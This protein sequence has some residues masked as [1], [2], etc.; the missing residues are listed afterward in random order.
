MRLRNIILVLALLALLAVFTGGSLYYFSLRQAAFTQAE[1]HAETRIEL[2]QK[3]LALYLTEHV[4][5]VKAL[6]GMEELRHAL[7]NN[8]PA[9]IARVNP[10]LDNFAGALDL[11]ACYLMDREGVTIAASNRH[12]QDSF[13]GKNFSFRPYFK[14]AAEGRTATYLALGTT[15]GKRGIYYSHP[16]L[17]RKSS[18]VLGAAIIKASV[19]LVESLVFTSNYQGTL[20][21][22]DPNGVIFIANKPEMRFMLLWQ[23]AGKDIESIKESRQFGAGP[24]PWSGLARKENRYV[25]NRQNE[26]FLFSSRKMQHYPGWQIVHLRSHRAIEKK[27]ADPFLTVIGPVILVVSLLTGLSIFILYS[28][29]LQEI[30]RRKTAEKELR[31]NEEKYRHIYHKTPVMLHS[32]DTKGKIIRVSDHWLEKMGYQRGEVIGRNLTRFYTES[33]KR[34][35]EEV[36][37]P[38][39]FRTGFCRNIP[40]TYVKKDG[41]TIDILLSCY[42]VRNQQGTVERSLAVSVDVTEKNQ[43]QNA[44]EQAKEKLSRYS[45]NLEQQVEKRTAELESTRDTLRKLSKNIMD[46]QERERGVLARELH[47]HLGQVLTALRI[48]AVGIAG[49]LDPGDKKGAVRADRICSLIDAT[50]DDVRD[51]AFRLR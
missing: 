48:D 14:K 41:K 21:V 50:I 39:F 31:L 16:V 9:S 45:G 7:K 13:V 40:Y 37:F 18:E 43:V 25:E 26:E 2:L 17:D 28:K 8:T 51:M 38:V 6:A 35:A 3:Q 24:W 32:I 42:G 19:E 1:D 49:H 47:D 22:T 12:E 11:E 29:A 46:A 27:I 34:Y 44:L 20:L 5:P 15:S 4:K 30:N 33:S 23:T 10:V 36:I